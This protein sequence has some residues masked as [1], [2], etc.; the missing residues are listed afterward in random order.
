MHVMNIAP[1]GTME[2]LHTEALPLHEFGAMTI[3]RA[4]TVEFNESTQLWEVRWPGSD[5]VVF[6]HTSRAECIR[7]EVAEINRRLEAAGEPEVLEPVLP[8]QAP[9]EAPA[10]F[11]NHII[12]PDGFVGKLSRPVRVF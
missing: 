7:W 10:V 5:A 8:V 1:D 6:S 12:E 2:C 11:I 9:G 4:S 3:R